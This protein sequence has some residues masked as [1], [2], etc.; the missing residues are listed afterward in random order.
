MTRIVL[1]LFPGLVFAAPKF[2]NTKCPHFWEMQT[3]RM[4]DFK[5]DMVSGFYYELAFHD[6]TQFPLCPDAHPKC[7]TA[8][9][10]VGTHTDGVRYMDDYWNLGCFGKF[11]PQDLLF[12]VTEHPGYFEGYVPVTKIPGLPKDIVKNT[13]FPASIIDFEPGEDG[14]SLELQCVEALGGVKFVGIN[15]YAK[16]RSVKAYNDMYRV[17]KETGIDHYAFQGFGLR[18]V[19]HHDCP[20]EPQSG[21]DYP[22]LQETT[23]VV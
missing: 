8:N 4:K 13:V 21:G 6:Y 15:F 3:E 11:Y 7:I 22:P 23:L 18:N 14:W 2:N 1:A 20:E 5:V 12:N 17:M 9:R 19:S 16:K 10:S